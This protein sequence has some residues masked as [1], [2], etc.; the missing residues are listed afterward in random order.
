L[1]PTAF[2][3]G[4]PLH[5]SY[6]PATPRWRRV[7]KQFMK[8]HL[9]ESYVLPNPVHLVRWLSC[10]LYGSDAGK[11]TVGGELTNRFEC[12]H[13]RNIAGV[14]GVRLYE[15]LKLGEQVAISVLRDQRL[16][17]AEDFEGSRSRVSTAARS[18]CRAAP[19]LR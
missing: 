14:H 12:R 18:Q 10:S 19:S 15:S 5:P 11:L 1:L 4:C 7:R 17:Y 3:E 13:G 16:T 6:G 8:G 2:P 9:D